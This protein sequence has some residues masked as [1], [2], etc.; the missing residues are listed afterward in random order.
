MRI[1]SCSEWVSDSYEWSIRRLTLDKGQT[2]YL[3]Q[4]YKE[5]LISGKCL[6]GP[7]VEV[8]GR[9]MESMNSR[10]GRAEMKE[11]A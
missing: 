1:L 2:K 3:V 10:L 6:I 7:T 9:R 4:E 11:G 5:E 8:R